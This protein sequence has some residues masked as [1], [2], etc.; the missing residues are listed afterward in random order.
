MSDPVMEDIFLGVSKSSSRTRA[1]YYIN[2]KLFFARPCASWVVGLG[3][4]IEGDC[5]RDIMNM[6]NGRSHTV[7][8]L[9]RFSD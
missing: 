8:L 3:S 2:A 1:C 6:G 7:E 9:S 4:A 5:P